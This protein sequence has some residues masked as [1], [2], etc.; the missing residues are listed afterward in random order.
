MFINIENSSQLYNVIKFFVEKL[1]K[2][3]GAE[4]EF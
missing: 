4:R 3:G 2:K 1:L